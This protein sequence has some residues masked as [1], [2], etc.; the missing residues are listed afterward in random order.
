M[1][2]IIK[3]Q[4][5]ALELSYFVELIKQEKPHG[6][7]SSFRHYLESTVLEQT[8]VADVGGK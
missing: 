3:D 1:S 8:K 4:Q 5:R 2:F 6:S 7:I